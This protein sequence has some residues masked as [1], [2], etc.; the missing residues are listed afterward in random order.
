VEVISGTPFAQFVEQRSFDPLD[1]PDTRLFR[2]DPAQGRFTAQY[3][4][5][6]EMKIELDDPATERS[7]WIAGGNRNVARGAGGLLSTAHDYVQ[8]QQMMLNGGRLDGVRLLAPLTVS[9]M[10]EN[11]TGTLP[12]WLP[13]P[14]M[15]FGLG[16][17]V[18]TDRGAAATPLSNGSAGWGGA[19]STTSW[20]DRSQEV[21]AGPMTQVRPY[22]HLDILRDFQNLVHQ[23]IVD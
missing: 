5:G 22:A 14:G 10:L 9:L 20:I 19:Y 15:G 4:P 3:K 17:G 13:G 12:L 21:V 11:H 16:Y 8:F 7:R 18:V 23:A 1:M 6:M 2:D